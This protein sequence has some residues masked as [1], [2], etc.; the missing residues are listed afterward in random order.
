[1]DKQSQSEPTLGYN[2]RSSMV[3]MLVVFFGVSTLL[4][5]ALLAA[6]VM[7]VYRSPGFH[8][9][10]AEVCHNKGDYHAACEECTTAIKLSPTFAKNY[11][12]RADIYRHLGMYQEEINDCNKALKLSPDNSEAHSLLGWAYCKTGKPRA[13]MEEADK[14]ILVD[15]SKQYLQDSYAT[16]G[17]AYYELGQYQLAVDW[18]TKA[19]PINPADPEP[20]AV[21]A[22]AYEKLG[23]KALAES[24]R[25]AA[26]LHHYVENKD[27]VKQW[28]SLKNPID[29]HLQICQPNHDFDGTHLS[30]HGDHPP[31]PAHSSRF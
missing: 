8:T 12:D 11:T 15:S 23:E 31:Q 19:I 25:Q 2:P 28:F 17:L 1:M 3:R 10:I 6:A 4:V 21:R 16:R 5:G 9:I 18:L 29:L 22:L 26:K 14:S 24:D 30:R 20:Y 27:A 13:G 7:F